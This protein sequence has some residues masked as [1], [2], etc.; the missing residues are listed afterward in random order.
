MAKN[1]TKDSVP[2][3]TGDDNGPDEYQAKA[4]AETLKSHAEIKS[5]PKRLAAATQHLATQKAAIG[6]AHANARRSLSQKTGQR[7]KQAFG[8]HGPEE[9]EGDENGQTPYEKSLANK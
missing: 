6:S 4:D 3:V 1:A 5:D 2:D 7:M 8:K 9:S